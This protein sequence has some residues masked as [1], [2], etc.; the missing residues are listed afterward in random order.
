MLTL[1]L[2]SPIGRLWNAGELLQR[3]THTL[4]SPGDHRRNPFL[5]SI[6]NAA[7]PM[8][9]G[10]D[11]NERYYIESA[12]HSPQVF[13]RLGEVVWDLGHHTR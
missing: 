6:P 9:L 10:P 5:Y 3:N 2:P 11:D 7:S 12:S 1:D 13:L 8:P 4:A